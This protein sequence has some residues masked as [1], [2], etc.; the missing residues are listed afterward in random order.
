METKSKKL[1]FVAFFST[2]AAIGLHIY[3]S[4]KF[5]SLKFGMDSSNACNINERFNCDI[6]STSQFADLFGVPIAL[7]GALTNAALFILMLNFYLNSSESRRAFRSGYYLSLFIFLVSIVMGTISVLFLSS[8]CPFCLATYALSL[9]TC[10]CLHFTSDKKITFSSLVP[11]LVTENRGTTYLVL[12]IPLLALFINW[13]INKGYSSDKLELFA[14]DAIQGWKSKE[15]VNFDSLRGLV[16]GSDTSKFVIVE[17]ADYLC[18]HC[19]HANG[20]LKTFV[21]TYPDTKIIFKPYPLDGTCNTS[22]ALQGQGDG[23]RCRLSF[24]SYCGEK[25]YKEGFKYHDFIFENQEFFHGVS[26]A[27]EVDKK[28]CSFDESRCVQMK[29]C[30]GSEDATNWVKTAA[31]EGEDAKIGG[32]PT[33][34]V[35]GKKLEGGQNV[36]ILKALYKEVKSSN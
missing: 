25:L 1:I 20:P 5:Y 35:N 19:K 23:I 34:F 30:M 27:E 4:F 26:N 16:K 14:R 31:K 2:L 21:S 9:I 18:P 22:P 3:L 33:I 8:Y 17:F 24:A 28:I 15:A 12:S 7:L 10:A 36:L 13:N 11:F 29:E 6:A 32:T